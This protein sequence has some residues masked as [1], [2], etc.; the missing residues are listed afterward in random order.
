M[1]SRRS[2]ERALVA[3]DAGEPASRSWT[4]A[5]TP[6]GRDVV[7]GGARRLTHPPP[8][9]PAGGG[10]PISPRPPPPPG[11]PRAP[12]RY[13]HRCARE[14][15]TVAGRGNAAGGKSGL[16]RAGCWVTPRG[17]NPTDQ[18]HRKETAA[19]EGGKGET[20]R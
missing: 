11:R 13:T 2:E 6:L 3:L 20:V 7:A 1:R 17:G 12:A 16:H 19:R 15:R 8:R 4:L 5:I 9:P 10:P 18:C 14:G